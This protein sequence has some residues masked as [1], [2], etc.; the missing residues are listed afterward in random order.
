MRKVKDWSKVNRDFSKATPREQWLLKI[1][2]E[3]KDCTIRRCFGCGK[4]ATT[5]TTKGKHAE[6]DLHLPRNY[7]WYCRKCWVR[8]VKIENEAMYG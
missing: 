5:Q 4:T 7:G 2:K 1:I 6:K 8:G 3:Y